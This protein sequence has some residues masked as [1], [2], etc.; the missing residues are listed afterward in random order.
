MKT[1]DTL[2]VCEECGGINIETRAWVDA[3][4][5]LYKSD[6]GD[7]DWCNDCE[8]HVN[9]C[10]KAEYIKKDEEFENIDEDEL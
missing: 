4:T 10:T 9:L 5:H 2:L 6:S 1:S 3:N 8:E 7:H